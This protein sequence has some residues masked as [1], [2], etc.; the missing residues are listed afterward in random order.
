AWNR[1]PEQGQASQDRV[2][3][4]LQ[5]DG[6]AGPTATRLASADDAVQIA[7][8][9]NPELQAAFAELGVAEADL[10]QAGRLPNPG[11]SF[12]RTHAGDDIK[13]ERSLSLGLMRLL[14]MP[15]TARIEQRRFEQV[16]LSLAARVLA[17]AAQTRQAYYQA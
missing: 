14:T 4:L 2:T 3:R 8:I 13:I 9:N 5:A 11:F 16:R 6:S 1:T 10:V 17:L 15:A 7:L 12:A